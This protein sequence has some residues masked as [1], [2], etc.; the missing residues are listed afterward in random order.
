MKRIVEFILEACFLK[1]IPRSGYQFLGAG[2]ESVAEHVYATTLIAFAMSQLEPKADARR[3]LPM[4]LLHDLPEART[5]DLNYV[6]KRY[7]A[8]D[9]DR[10]LADAV[11]GL[12]FEGNVTDFIK[13]FNAGDTLEAK[14]ARDADQLALMTDLKAL[15]DLGYQ[16]PQSWLPHVRLRLQTEVACK[17]ADA[18]LDN[19]RDGW[20]LKLFRDIPEHVGGQECRPSTKEKPNG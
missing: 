6:Q 3:L 4:C 7:A 8:V 10:A 19:H 5:G 12:P 2:R 14:L 17:L 16:T 18:L 9:E 15:H 1:Q 11:K 20:W 13:E